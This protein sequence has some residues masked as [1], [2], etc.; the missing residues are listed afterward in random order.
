MNNIPG[1]NSQEKTWLSIL[2]CKVGLVCKVQH[3]K[4]LMI[5]FQPYFIWI[6]K[7]T[8]KMNVCSIYLNKYR[9]RQTNK[10]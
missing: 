5:D 2:Q 9:G 7:N 3:F 1:K 10:M 4:N 6:S 8:Q